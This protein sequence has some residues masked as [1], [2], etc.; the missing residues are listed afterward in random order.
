MI[1]RIYDG[2][3]QLSRTLQE[4]VLAAEDVLDLDESGRSQATN[5]RDTIQSVM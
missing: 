4:L 2:K 1:D 3:T 5:Y